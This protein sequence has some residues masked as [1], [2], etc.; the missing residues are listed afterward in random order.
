VKSKKES[1]TKHAVQRADLRYGVRLNEND[2]R[3]IVKLIETG[4]SKPL[5]KQSNRVVVHKVSYKSCDMILVYDK[6]RKSI[7]TFLPSDSEGNVGN[8]NMEFWK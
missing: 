7:A 5:Q 1:Q 8:P 6:L 2:L 3:E 4:K